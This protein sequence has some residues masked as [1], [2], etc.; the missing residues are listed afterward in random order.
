MN[1]SQYLSISK[2]QYKNTGE[3]KAIPTQNITCDTTPT[4]LAKRETKN[5]RNIRQKN[6]NDFAPLR[7]SSTCVTQNMITKRLK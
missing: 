7:L 3:L 2:F 5:L 6:R 1:Y 4:C